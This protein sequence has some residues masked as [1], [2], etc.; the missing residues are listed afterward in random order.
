MGHARFL[1]SSLFICFAGYIG[2][3]LVG[4]SPLYCAVT[5][6]FAD[7]SPCYKF[8]VR[9]QTADIVLVG[10]SSL[11]YAI[12]PK[13]VRSLTG[14][15]VYNYGLV[16]PVFAFDPQS[17]IDHYLATNR[18]PRAIIAYVSPW[19]V[20]EPGRIHDPFWFPIGLAALQFPRVISFRQIVWTRPSAL[21]E[22]APIIASSVGRDTSR[23]AALRADPELMHRHLGV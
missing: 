19:D 1:L 9:G 17:V 13:L 23:P 3:S 16:G 18:R 12:R 22:L 14:R 10:D 8:S 7:T 6:S 21:V 5:K 20:V 11:L 4:G 15:S 2:L